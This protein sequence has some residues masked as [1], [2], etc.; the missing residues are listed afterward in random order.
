MRINERNQL[1]AKKS[2]LIDQTLKRH[3]RLLQAFCLCWEDAWQELA[4][5]MLECLDVYDANL[6]SNLD[7]YLVKQMN[8]TLFHQLAP[9][10]RYGIPNAPRVQDFQVI[11]L[12]D[13]HMSSPPADKPEELLWMQ[14]EIAALPD[15]QRAMIQRL[16]NGDKIRSSNKA[17]QS[18]RLRLR[19]NGMTS[20]GRLYFK[21]KGA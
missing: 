6:C 20:F 2:A 9:S 17:L 7:A 18:A 11:S 5:R 15:S 13:Y 14:E 12:E 19:K 8:Y 1:F 4:V 16:L 3:N 21:K 10:K